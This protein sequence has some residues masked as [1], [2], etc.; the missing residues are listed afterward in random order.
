MAKSMDEKA[1][2]LLETLSMVGDMRNAILQTNLPETGKILK[3]CWRLKKASHG[4]ENSN[5]DDL[6][7]IGMANGAYGAKVTGSVSDG[8]GHLVFLAPFDSCRKIEDAIPLDRMDVKFEGKG[9]RWID[10]R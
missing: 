1:E 7:E 9:C 4:I 8:C 5:I 10:V 3:E 6:I 2:F